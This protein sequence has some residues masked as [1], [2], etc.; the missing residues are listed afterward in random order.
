MPAHVPRRW[1]AIAP[2]VQQELEIFTNHE[3]AQQQ[4]VHDT[5]RMVGHD[6]E[7]PIRRD[8][9]DQLRRHV[10]SDLEDTDGIVPQAAVSGAP[11]LVG[12]VLLLEATL[13]GQHLDKSDQAALRCS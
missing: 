7:R 13:T 4:S 2:A 1:S 12:V 6:H 8:A 10:H 3:P 9:P 5:E 11:C